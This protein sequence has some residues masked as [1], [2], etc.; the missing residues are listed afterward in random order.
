MTE[1]KTAVYTH[2]DGYVPAFEVKIQGQS[3]DREVIRD[4]ISVT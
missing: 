1:T 3:L 2:Y 4:V